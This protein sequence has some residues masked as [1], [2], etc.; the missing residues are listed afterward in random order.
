VTHQDSAPE[1]PREAPLGNSPRG[2]PGGH[3]GRRGAGQRRT[4]HGS[5]PGAVTPV[6]S[7]APRATPGGHP[8]ID[9]MPGRSG[10]PTATSPSPPSA[11]P[12][13]AAL[14]S[15]TRFN[16][17]RY[18]RQRGASGCWAFQRAW[19]D[20]ASRPGDGPNSPCVQGPEGA[21][22]WTWQR[23]STGCITPTCCAGSTSGLRTD[24]VSRAATG[25][26]R[27]G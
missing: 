5:R 21:S 24:G 19:R 4:T 10:R 17:G 7:G 15:P 2:T 18:P 8:S 25:S 16:G 1:T 6:P 23:S 11:R 3:A 13:V 27:R 9:G 14:M 12:C 22:I 20:V 26:C